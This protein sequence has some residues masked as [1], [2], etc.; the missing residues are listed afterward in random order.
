MPW[1]VLTAYCLE[2]LKSD[3]QNVAFDLRR[4][5]LLMTVMI[6]HIVSCVSCLVT[7]A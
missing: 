4:N 5:S 2:P 3:D 6:F 7:L 1:S